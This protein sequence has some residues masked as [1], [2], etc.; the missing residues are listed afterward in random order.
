MLTRALIVVLVLLNISVGLWW[1]LRGEPAEQPIPAASGV[2]QLELIAAGQAPARAPADTAL[3]D[4]TTE[5]AATAP[6]QPAAPAEPVP[7]A[8]AADQATAAAPAVAAAPQSPPAPRAEA[9]PA[10]CAAF[11]PFADQ[12]AATEAQQRL[13]TDL[14]QARRVSEPGNA[15]DTRYRVMLPPAAD[16]AAAQAMVQRIQAAGLGDYYIIA[17]GPQA[18]AIALGQY[19]NREGAQRRLA[20]VQAAGFAAELTGGEPPPRWWLQGQLATA[21]DANGL[22]QRSGAA[23]Q[24]RLEC[25]VL[26]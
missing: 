6:A 19:R 9:A 13:G 15:A 23:Q 8:P 18:N 10:R 17:D 12:A 16:R 1:M 24:R 5:P 7:V 3:A 11:G 14:L 26:R 4:A 20:A 21:A 22:R 25:S 2:A